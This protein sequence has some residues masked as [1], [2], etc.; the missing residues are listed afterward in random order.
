[1]CFISK[2]S[3]VYLKDFGADTQNIFANSDLIKFF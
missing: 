1:M 3:Y 2:L